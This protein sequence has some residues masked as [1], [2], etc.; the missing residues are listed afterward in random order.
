MF[1]LFKRKNKIKE[2]ETRILVL[3]SNIIALNMQKENHIDFN[4]INKVNGDLVL[5]IDGAVIGKVA[6]EQLDKMQRQGEITLIP[7]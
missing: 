2:L 5:Q 7:V 4:K 1:N 6:L 3:E